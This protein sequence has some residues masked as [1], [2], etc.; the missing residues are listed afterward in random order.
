LPAELEVD[1][2]FLA[3]FPLPQ[4]GDETSKAARGTVL[5]VGGSVQTL[6]ASLLAGTAALRS[7]AGKLQLAADRA[8]VIPLALAIPEARV[9][10]NEECE[11]LAS[12]ADA[13]LVGPGIL[14][15]ETGEGIM[16]RIAQCI[17]G[18]T[19]LVIDAGALAGEEYVRRRPRTIAIPNV[20]EAAQILDSEPNHVS[21]NPRDA[22]AALV[23]Q[24]GMTVA[25]R[26]AVTW[27]GTPNGERFVDRSGHAALATSG[28]GD[29]AAGIIAGLAA[30]GAEPLTAALWGVHTHGRIGERVAARDRGIGALARDFLA[31]IPA[32]LNTVCAVDRF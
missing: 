13:V 1:D 7:G 10:P 11:E 20:V 23:D 2:A 27:I 12:S 8:A 26:D 28:S 31:E 6:G 15:A 9:A 29:V 19:M 16:K 21:A 18:E 32:T 22:L 4:Y 17:S 3:R 5:V 24:L 14:D 30:R 25:L